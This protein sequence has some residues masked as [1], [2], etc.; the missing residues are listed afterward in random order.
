RAVDEMP[1]VEGVRRD[2][3]D[4]RVPRRPRRRARPG[5]ADKDEDRAAILRERVGCRHAMTPIVPRW[6]WRTFG[7]SFADADPQLDA[8]AA[9]RTQ[10]SDE[11]YLLS[12]RGD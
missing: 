4:D 11:L 6:E 7:Q 12:G 10:E 2:G 9:E 1:A 8:L 5:S 3:S